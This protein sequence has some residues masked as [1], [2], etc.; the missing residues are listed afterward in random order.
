MYTVKLSRR[1][2]AVKVRHIEQSVKLTHR[3]HN[4]RFVS[5]GRKGDQGVPGQKGDTGHGIPAGGL[6]D[7]VLQKASND[8]FDFQWLQ[9]TYSD[10]NFTTEFTVTNEILVEHNLN[11]YP[12]VTVIDS[13]G[14]EVET[15][16]DY[17][18]TNSL[19]VTFQY[20]FSGRITCN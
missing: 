16:V 19:L 20:P 17:I 8:D 13:A 7:Q 2:H 10:K 4:I 3:E 6:K 11:K 14:D 1:N 5:T 18:N 9:P 15:G 12:T